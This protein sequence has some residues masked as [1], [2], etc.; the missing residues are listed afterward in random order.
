MEE[1]E[2]SS[3]GSRAEEEVDDVVEKEEAVEVDEDV[4]LQSEGLIVERL[5]L[6][7][8]VEDDDE[9]DEVGEEVEDEED[10]DIDDPVLNTVFLLEARSFFFDTKGDMSSP[11]RGKGIGVV[12][13]TLV[14]S[15]LSE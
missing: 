13:F 4:V 11:R 3:S 12:S 10:G 15:D 5:P 2:L 8:T 7:L 9:V 6:P 1:S 14:H